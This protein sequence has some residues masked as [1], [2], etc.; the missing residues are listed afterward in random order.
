MFVYYA[1]NMTIFL[2]LK[3]QQNSDVGNAITLDC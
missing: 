3:E 1:H 2:L